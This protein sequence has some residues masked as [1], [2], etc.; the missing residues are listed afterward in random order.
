VIEHVSEQSPEI[1]QGVD[2]GGAGDQGIMVGYATNETE[3]GE[4]VRAVVLDPLL[5][6]QVV[7]TPCHVLPFCRTIALLLQRLLVLM[8][9]FQ[10]P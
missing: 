3:E 9:N 5:F 1:A 2:T 10:L 8:Q 7:H 4:E 6:F